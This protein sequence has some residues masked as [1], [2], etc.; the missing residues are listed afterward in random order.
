LAPMC[1]TREPDSRTEGGMR[2]GRTAVAALAALAAL[3]LGAC[4]AVEKI[5]GPPEPTP[6]D[7]SPR[8]AK[9]KVEAYLAA[10]TAKNVK[11]GRLQLCPSLYGIFDKTATGT[12]GDF[13][14]GV[15]VSDA[16]VTDVR[17]DGPAQKVTAAL[18]V[19]AGGASGPVGIAFTVSRIE[20]GWCIAGEEPA[21]PL[22][23]AAPSAS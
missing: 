14:R 4:D 10:M 18:T 16:T 7:E 5:T 12:G 11:A 19:T 9:E 21:V 20:S 13:A 23:S 8:L 1:Q 2:A 17:K 3:G 22:P 15:S 6:V